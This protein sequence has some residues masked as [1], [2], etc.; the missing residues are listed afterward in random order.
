MP[1]LAAYHAGSAAERGFWIRTIEA[2]EQTEADLDQATR[3]IEMH[4]GVGATLA[5]AASYA[6]AAKVALG[7]F[8]R[9]ALSE[10]LLEIADYTVSRAK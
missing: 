5:R 2:S 7:R 1:V 4:D 9:S 6:A 10:S 3:L 8:K